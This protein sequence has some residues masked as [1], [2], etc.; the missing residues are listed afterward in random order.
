MKKLIRELKE[1]NVLTYIFAF[2]AVVILT[3]AI[4][5]AYL[6]HFY[7]QT[8]YAD[9][10]ATNREHLQT[11]ENRHESDLQI[12]DD[13][14]YQV[15]ISDDVT[16][17]SLEKEPIKAKRL[18]DQLHQY[19]SVSQF[20]SLL[21][22]FYHG[23][24]Y[25][26]SDTTSVDE[27]I[28]FS[29]CVLETMDP[30]AFREEMYSEG[31]ELR[32][33]PEQS[34]A[35][36]W[37]NRY[38][39]DPEIV[40]YMRT[41]PPEFKE[42]MIFFVPT[43][44]YDTLLSREEGDLRG[45]YILYDGQVIARRSELQIPEE[46]I[47]AAVSS[48]LGQEK[49]ELED[50]EYLL[51]V[52]PGKS[53]LTYCTL[54]SMEIFHDKIVTEQWGIIAIL[55]L[56]AFPAGLLI[57][58]LSRRLAGR[59][60]KLNQMLD[61]QEEANYHLSSI[62]SGIQMLVESNEQKEQESLQLKKTRFIRNFVQSD[63]Q[64]EEEAAKAAADAS[65]MTGKEYVVVLLDGRNYNNDSRAHRRMLN[66]IAQSAHLDGYGIHLVSSSQNLFVLFADEKEDLEA[67]LGAIF[68]VGKEFC[69]DF[70]MAS[71]SLHSRLTE[72]AQAYLE[73]D[74]AFYNRFLRDNNK[75]IRFDQ[76]DTG[77]E[78]NVLPD[79]YL[80]NLR[81]ALRSRD[82]DAVREA[83]SQ[84]CVKM[85]KESPSLY[86]FRI[87]YNDIIHVMLSE[88]KEGAGTT[89]NFYNVFAL[90]QCLTI[91]DFNDLLYEACSQIIDS[92]TGGEP[93]KSEVIQEAVRY[94]QEHFS[95]PDLT[96]NALAEKLGVSSA[97]FSV[98]FRNETGVRPSDYLANL[99]ME[100]AGE[101]LI[102][103]SMLI[104]EISTAVGY[105]D[106]HV[107]TRRF[108]KYTGKTPGQYREEHL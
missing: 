25:L 105:E 8:I 108:K 106:D 32:V 15:G 13:I 2:S 37:I 82:K 22:Y 83:I 5:G 6:Y 104:R 78:V 52:S 26:Y 99:R 80:Q 94:M 62:E 58:I 57:M 35:G 64:D 72:G 17:F 31:H 60:R 56:C 53:G 45:D 79:S 47:S 7:Y 4:L 43:S 90:S 70:V 71:S 89:E 63:F 69:E 96:M 81:Y 21:F 50:E 42:T 44:Y 30:Q 88:W 33:F 29:N 3:I 19:I 97:T 20:F 76:A 65:I 48:S 18:E 92:H 101:L 27:D 73:A 59:V 9:F 23:D 11:I 24:S 49:V 38:L 10:Q 95:D 16:S 28:F 87:L 102:S 34:V 39:S 107:F 14:I 93:E 40:I 75:I 74:T 100:K 1:Q 67:V 41:I 77:G 55:I 98:A 12:M 51:T 36:T 54:Q 86:A 85:T 68:E 91:Q 61:S 66:I 46:Q 84:I 103:T